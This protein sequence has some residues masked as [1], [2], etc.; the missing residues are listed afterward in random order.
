MTSTLAFDGVTRTFRGGGG[1]TTVSLQVAPGEIVALLGLNGAGKTTLMRLALGILR[2]GRGSV[3]L[4][5]RALPAVPPEC[6]AQ[7][8]A[9]IEAPAAYPELTV[10]ENLHIARRLRGGAP[11][12]V[13]AAVAAWQLGAVVDRRFRR[14]SMGNRQRVGLAAALQHDPALI[15]LDEPTTALDP[16]SVLLLREQLFNRAGHGAGI[17]ISSHHLDE[18]AR[19]AD[20]VLLMNAGHLIGELET[21]GPDLERVF[22]DRIREDDERRRRPG[23]VAG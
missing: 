13:E 19:I 8:G 6:W 17:L 4:F 23:R 12:I 20:R 11:E 5:G 10:A 22:F 16:T 14:L 9:V 18:V 21:A 3:R 2:P 1:V 15:V 7:V